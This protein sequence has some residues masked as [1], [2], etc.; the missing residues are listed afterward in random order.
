MNR[1]S[2]ENSAYLRHA[3]HQK[4]DWHPWSDE[5]FERAE[6]EDKPVFLSTGAVWCHWCHVMAKECFENEEI[7]NILNE[8]F[9][10]IKLDR[11]EKPDIDRMYQHAAAV[12]GVGGGW[13]LSVFLT[14]DR[15]PFFGGTYFPPEDRFGRP[16]FRKVLTAVIELYKTKKNE[17]SDYTNKV[18]HALKPHPVIH[19][20]LQESSLES[21][22]EKILAA[23]DAQH[24][25]F[26]TAPKFPMTGA[27]EFLIN[28]YALTK[29]ESIGFAVKKTVDSMAKGGFHDQI[30][31]G[32]HRYSTDEAWIVPHFE[33]MAD[34]NAWLLRNYIDAYA[35]FGLEYFREVAEGIINFIQEVLSDPDGGFYASQDA[36]ITPDDEGGYFTWTDED[37][38]QVLNDEEYRVLSLHLL[39]DR[40]EMH[41]DVS[42]KVLFVSVE[43]DEISQKLKMDREKL[44]EIINSGKNKL[45]GKRKTRETPFIDKTCYTSLNG[46]LIAAF[47]KASRI[48]GDNSIK[49]F[50]LRSIDR[51][52]KRFFVGNELFH[53]EGVKALLDDYVNFGEA[54]VTAYEVTGESN[55]LKKADDLLETCLEKLWDSEE[56][57]FFETETRLIDT[58]LK[59][60]EDVSHPSSNALGIRL[61]LK[62]YQL[63]EKEKYLQYAE[64]SL[65]AFSSRA[66]SQTLIAGYYFAALDEYFHMLKLTL[67]TSDR[68]LIDTALSFYSPYASIAYGEDKGFVLPCIK[69]RCLEPISDVHELKQF[70][71]KSPLSY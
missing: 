13:P 40:G 49:I 26:G 39:H 16:G 45:L 37:F 22:L 55:Y 15:K 68:Q 10:N 64:K 53:S 59:G 57:G 50:A 52:M 56:G 19:E 58:R 12:M 25:G 48:L 71:S 65:K 35:V 51:V 70:L 34:D 54:L 33:K 63:T 7:A 41:H 30:Q 21:A 1:L 62:L 18:V 14:P 29:K 28:R 60:I 47:L 4:I 43:E 66:K 17:I 8:H 36:D 32:F 20:D 38:K 23:V 27:L 67:H 42:K 24:G 5:A 44:K 9:V 69:T 61:L 11:D 3:A 6:Q 2:N 31:G 46:M